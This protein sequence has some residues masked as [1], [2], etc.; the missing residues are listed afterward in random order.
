MT[1]AALV[2]RALEVEL[3]G[4]VE[5]G[6]RGGG[7]VAVQ[8]GDV[9]GVGGGVG[10]HGPVSPDSRNR[11]VPDWDSILAVGREARVLVPARDT[12][13]QEPDPLEEIA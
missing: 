13:S 3:D 7:S 10:E 11:V 8:G 2:E 9:G 4:Y 6:A 1:I 5:S 12:V